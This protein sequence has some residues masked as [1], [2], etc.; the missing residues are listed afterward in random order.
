[1]GQSALSSAPVYVAGACRGV[2]VG[3]VEGVAQCVVYSCCDMRSSF[4]AGLHAMVC[5]PLLLRG[6]TTSICYD[7]RF[8]HRVMGTDF[9]GRVVAG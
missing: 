1:M 8:N 3:L 9:S 4:S 2:R 5:E 7:D 6:R